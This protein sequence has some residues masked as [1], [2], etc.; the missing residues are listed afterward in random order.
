MFKNKFIN[1]SSI[2]LVLFSLKIQRTLIQAKHNTSFFTL[3][4]KK[5]L[6]KPLKVATVQKTFSPVGVLLLQLASIN[7]FYYL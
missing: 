1:I 4:E 5:R 7:V 6:T 2:H 3:S